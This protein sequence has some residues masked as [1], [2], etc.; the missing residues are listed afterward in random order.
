MIR[1][2]CVQQPSLRFNTMAQRYSHACDQN[3]DGSKAA[4]IH[5][6]DV[7]IYSIHRSLNPLKLT[8][9]EQ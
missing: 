6:K 3:L 7:Q 4:A 2:L 8:S 9:Q 5:S 1:A